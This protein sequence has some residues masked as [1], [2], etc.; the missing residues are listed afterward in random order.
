MDEGMQLIDGFLLWGGGVVGGLVAVEADFARP[1]GKSRRDAVRC[2]QA[3]EA[4]GKR[5]VG[6]IRRQFDEGDFEGLAVGHC[7]GVEQSSAAAGRGLQVESPDFGGQVGRGFQRGAGREVTNLRKVFGDIADC[8]VR[9]N[10]GAGNG[11]GGNCTV[12]ARTGEEHPIRAAGAI[13][14]LRVAAAQLER[15]IFGTAMRT[16]DDQDD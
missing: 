8:L 3:G 9:R 1:F 12:A 15:G 5:G 6:N 10:S 7:G 13:R 14:P 11:A 4:G 2:S 16:I